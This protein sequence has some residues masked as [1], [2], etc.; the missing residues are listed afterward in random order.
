MGAPAAAAPLPVVAALILRDD[1]RCLMCQRSE[2][3]KRPL[4]W[5]FPGGKIEPGETGPEA[6][7]RECREELAI[8][9]RVRGPV[10]ETVYAYPDV[11]IRL[12]LYACAIVSG[13]PKALEHRALR[14]TTRGELASL[15]LCPADR[16]L[17]EALSPDLLK[18]S[19][20]TEDA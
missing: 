6:L 7:R 15:P 20:S 11:T 4:G 3:M 5:E 13:E 2:A 16:R 14:W 17:A 19:V 10:A 18:L 9:L 8:D 12:T 1:G